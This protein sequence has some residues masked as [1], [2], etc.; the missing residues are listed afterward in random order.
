MSLGPDR[1]SG[2]RRSI[3]DVRWA[4]ERRL[5]RLSP[6][7]ALEAAENGAVLVDI[8]SEEERQRDGVIPGALHHPLSVLTGASTRTLRRTTRSCRSTRT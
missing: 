3:E 4:A 5:L 2:T 6:R 1:R 7:E 8:R